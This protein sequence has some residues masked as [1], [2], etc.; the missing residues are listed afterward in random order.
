MVARAK[1]VECAA[2]GRTLS[3]ECQR[4]GSYDPDGGGVRAAVDGG[5][6]CRRIFGLGHF[7]CC[8]TLGLLGNSSAIER[9]IYGDRDVATRVATAV[10]ANPPPLSRQDAG[11]TV[12]PARETAG[13][14][15]RPRFG[16]RQDVGTAG[17]LDMI[18]TITPLR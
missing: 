5:V 16:G 3:D 9:C 6:R 13:T 14:S 15:E 17:V 7:F 1:T 2:R 4:G 11:D 10:S 18:R 12:T 8:R